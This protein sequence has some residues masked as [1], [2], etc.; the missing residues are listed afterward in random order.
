MYRITSMGAVIHII[1]L[2][3]LTATLPQAVAADVPAPTI[4]SFTPNSAYVGEYGDV[5]TITGVHFTGT[6]RVAFNYNALVATF[7]VDNDTTIRT[8]VPEGVMTD[9]ICVTTPGGTALSPGNFT[10]MPIP[11]P[12]IASF[13]PDR[14]YVGEYGQTVTIKGTNFN[15][16]GRNFTGT[17]RVAFNYNA[18][19]AE[20]K[21]I[22]DT[23]I[24]AIVPEGVMTEVICVVTAGGTALSPYGFTVMPIPQPTITS[25]SP[26]TAYVGEHGQTV[27]IKGTYF[28]GAGR[29]F[30]GTTRVAF[31]YNALPAEFTVIDDTTI[32]AIVPE[33]VMTDVICVVTSGGTALSPYAFKVVPIP[34]PSISSFTPDNAQEGVFGQKITIRGTGFKG[35]GHN[36]TGTTQVAFNHGALIASFTVIDASTIEAV[37]PEGVVTDYISVVTSGGTATSNTPFIVW[38]PVT[39]NVAVYPGAEYL[40]SINGMGLSYRL[41]GTKAYAGSLDLNGNGV[42]TITGLRP[43]SYKLSIYGS[44][45]LV[46][47]TMHEY[48]IPETGLIQLSL[49]NGD[50][51]GDNRVNLFDFVVLDTKFGTSNSMA[52]LDGDGTVNLFD[53]VIIDR[54]FG[55]Q[56]DT[57]LHQ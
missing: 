12:T 57:F 46:S 26:D 28:N 55:A 38:Q 41:V 54:Y 37:V 25:F 22:D 51:D 20:F 14:A 4:T 3:L 8:I 10:V 2:A 53:Y 17:T 44:H 50:A 19:P 18:L 11:G 5:V 39:L 29:N 45:W 1:L 27:T 48:A 43:G 40:G 52:D 13:S 33:G 35:A 34:P 32:K 31:N 9:V 24:E 49:A 56:G 47:T 7:T 23:T 42:M 36:F 6:T 21:V 30:T 15:G 16:A